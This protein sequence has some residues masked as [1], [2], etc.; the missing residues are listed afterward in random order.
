[1]AAPLT[2]DHPSIADQYEPIHQIGQ[3]QP[4]GVLLVL[5]SSGLRILQASQNTQ[6]YLGLAPEQLLGQPF[7]AIV[8]DSTIERLANAL[9]P[10]TGETGNPFPVSLA[11]RQ[12]SKQPGPAPTFM[13]SAHRVS[14]M[15]IVE[16][17]PIATPE[18]FQGTQF[19]G[20]LNHILAAIR[21]AP[22]LAD[23]L[24]QGATAVRNLTHFDRVMVYRFD[25]DY[26]GVV[27][28]ES[29]RSG[30]E[31]YLGL[32]YPAV[33][34][35]PKARELFTRRWLRL[36]P[37]VN[38][39]PVGLVSLDATSESREAWASPLDLSQS[40]LRGVSPCHLEYLRNMGV[41]A[42]MTIPLIDQNQLWGLI[43]CHHYTPKLAE[44]EVRRICEL[45][46]QLM[47]VELLLRQERELQ[48]YREQIR[49]IE[50]DFRR[51]LAHSPSQIKTVLKRSQDILLDLIRAQGVAIVLD[52][53]I[54]LGGQ[55]P[56]KEQIRHLLNW[57]QTRETSEVFSTDILVD[58]YP[59][60]ARFRHRPSG[61]LAIS[62]STNQASYHI[63]WFRPE[64]SYT[65]NWGGNP[66]EAISLTPDGT[67][68]L[69]PR[70]S[71][72]LW[73]ELVSHRSLPWKVLEIEAAREL[74]HS[75]SIAA[76]ES[77]QIALQAA[78]AL[79][80]KA[81]QAKSEFLAN[82]SH[83]IRTP[84]NAILGFTQLLETTS[85]D[86]EQQGF[87]QS[88]AHGGESL[89]AII[90]DILDLSKLEAGELKL[91]TVEFSL[92]GMITDLVSLFQPQAQSKGLLLEAS[93][94]PD[95]PNR[96]LG[97]V[98]R[99]RQVLT[100]LISNAIKFTATGTVRL[101]IKRW[102]E[103]DD[104]SI[105][106]LHFQV[107]DTGI[108][109]APADQT[110]IFE[111]FTQVET[112]ATRQY[113]GTG[114]GLTIC[115]KIV[116]LMGGDIGVE[117]ALGK[118][119]TFWFTASLESLQSQL[120]PALHSTASDCTV[121]PST[122]RI[123]LVEDTPLNQKLML[124]MLKR[125]G[126]EADAVSDGQQALDQLDTRTYD[127]V[128]MDCQMPILDGYEATRQLRIQESQRSQQGQ[129]HRTTVIGVTAY[130]MVGDQ[131]K[132]LA[133]GMDDYLSKPIK[134][135]D[136]KSLLERWL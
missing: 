133:A 46:G 103:S 47:S 23:L 93:I 57:L 117:S 32:H 121:V 76:L 81:N 70:S 118:G 78:A 55:T 109:L 108:G 25:H 29:R 58:H 11:G 125:L 86:S 132:C 42:S 17:E 63:I 2:A 119:A 135:N 1:M 128:L 110:R 13:A 48:S 36:I 124:Q 114:L 61:I 24:Q 39:R 33:D 10:E 127:I 112:S 101:T 34:I 31:S 41:A 75:L 27:V 105:I 12:G 80:E 99:L 107:Q 59:E 83:E 74:R 64:Q 67:V 7:A 85:L 136:L 20:R 60:A 89:L 5:Q 100:N 35:P 72:A 21:R 79:A 30:L 130:A 71:F 14:G 6:D 43:A 97:P 51:Q 131:E 92:R 52:Q 123:L 106:K 66:R 134:L 26:S 16:M 102:E 111:P 95:V 91:D 115:R 56:T 50:E 9:A 104:D 98:D 90:N 4:H 129:P 45:M 73:K 84:M 28:A 94:T 40:E 122:A 8:K 54:V 38:Y 96:L 49:Q 120:T 69:S 113:E 77:S 19:Y 88:I 18:N 126:Y 53:V 82:M 62:V 87:V 37:D 116:R 44:Y 15:L 3:I 65:V 22:T 68:R